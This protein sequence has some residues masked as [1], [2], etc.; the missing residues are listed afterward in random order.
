MAR[1]I[2]APTDLAGCVLWFDAKDLSSITKD[3]SNRVSQW[4]DK[5]ASAAHAVQAVDAN[6]PT[7]SASGF[8]GLPCLDWGNG[9]PTARVLT[10]PS[11]S[12]GVFTLFVVATS[13]PGTAYVYVHNS[14][15]GADR[16]YLNND[17]NP[18]FAIRRAN[19]AQDSKRVLSGVLLDANRHIF[20][21]SYNGTSNGN[22]FRYDGRADGTLTTAGAD[23]G[24]TAT[25]GAIYLGNHDGA[26]LPL[27]GVIAEFI[28]YNRVLSDGEIVMVE[29]H[30]SRKW[31]VAL[32]IGRLISSP[33]DIPDCAMWFD[34]AQGVSSDVNGVSQWNDAS[35]NARHVAQSSNS[36][37][38]TYTASNAL[39]AG[40]PTVDYAAGTGQ[41]L[42]RGAA[43]NLAQPLTIFAVASLGAANTLQKALFNN[44][45][46]TEHTIVIRDTVAN[47]WQ[48]F[49]AGSL[50]NF[51]Y[52]DVS[53]K[54]FVLS[55]AS[56]TAG[57][58]LAVN[59]V[60]LANVGTTFSG[61]AISTFRLGGN[62]DGALVTRNWFGSIAEFLVYTR[63]LT[64]GE[65]AAVEAYLKRKYA[66]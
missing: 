10:T 30:L 64:L 15:A 60:V 24:L 50:S 37:K 61:T 52:P 5:S 18:N 25:A 12:Y 57:I 27:R 4:S 62:V 56:G 36:L 22:L 59:G 46:G 38:P 33:L 11:I 6:K 55:A 28:I 48:W 41:R 13:G 1:V 51:P 23:P 54:P 19:G 58:R 53:T 40:K 7:Y 8:G 39:F 14:T 16:E 45:S 65:I 32:Q 49:S 43:D 2:S 44:A 9:S 47:G 26:T 21:R 20:A 3:G 42:D 29:Q 35:G 63:R 17:P 34:A 31:K 66:L